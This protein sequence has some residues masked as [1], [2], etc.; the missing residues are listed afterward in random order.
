MKYLVIIFFCFCI[1]C[2]AKA[3][4][5]FTYG[6]NETTAS[7]FLRAYNKNKPAPIDKE[8]SIREYLDLYINFKLKVKAAEEIRL[9]T[10]SQI[11]FDVQNF[12]NQIV[13]NYMNDEQGLQRLVDEAAERSTKDIHALYFLVPVAANASSTDTAKAME[14]ATMLYKMLNSTRIDYPEI[15]AE[16]SNKFYPCKYADA[17][18]VTTFMLPYAYENILYNTPINNVSKPY[19]GSK[20]WVILKP[21][22]ERLAIGKWKV[23]Q[24]LFAFPP[25]ADNTAKQIIKN[26]ADSVYKLLQAGLSFNEAAKQFSDDRANYLSGGL[27]PEF[28]TGTYQN[29]FEANVIALKKD[30]DIST[31]F[32]TNFGYHIVKRLGVVPVPTNKNDVGFQF[33]LKQKIG[34][35]ERINSEREKF[36]DVIKNT[37]GYKRNIKITDA[38]LF[39][40]ADSIIKSTNESNIDKSFS[41]KTIATFTDGS[42]IKGQAWINFLKEEKANVELPKVNNTTLLENFNKQNIVTYYKANL[43]KYNVA[44]KTQMQEF[45]E[46]NMLF[47]MM[48]RNVWSKA[49]ADTIELKNYYTAHSNNYKWAESA[50]IIVF[51]SSDKTKLTEAYTELKQGGNWQSILQKSNNILLADSG[52]YE[53]SQIQNTATKVIPTAGEFSEIITNSNDAGYSFVKYIHLYPSNMQ[54]SFAEAKG[55]VINDYQNII[56]QQW[57]GEL[58]KKYPIKVNEAVLKQI[59]V[60]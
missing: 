12:R 50:D 3:Q 41:N 47:E 44:F 46:G 51:N 38:V 52:R 28:G 13:D 10:I 57:V 56:E 11:K 23:A 20:G 1:V 33:E 19:K 55:L 32:E 29:P 14:A 21:T 31:P 48:E 18:F 25:N 36:A 58:K 30:N 27:L 53:L 43:E 24:L 35:D 9:D 17:G 8:K 42:S 49:G 6:K 34:Q 2:D 45:K 54:R 4:T 60:K 40:I 7:E 16:V 5:V 26:K 39:A 22:E 59:L 37:T 15:V